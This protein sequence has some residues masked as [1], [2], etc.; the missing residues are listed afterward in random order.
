[1]LIQFWPITKIRTKRLPHDVPYLLLLILVLFNLFFITYSLQKHAAFQTAGFDL[2]NYNQAM[3]NT[4]QG[5]PLSITTMQTVSSRW[6]LHFEPILLL[7]TPVY[8][9]F[10][11]PQTLLVL[12]VVIVSLG[13]IPVF[14]LAQKVLVSDLAALIFAV[15]YLLFPALQGALV[16]DF[17]ALALAPAFLAWALWFMV[18]QRYGLVLIMVLLAMGCKENVALMV[19]MLGGYITFIQRQYRWGAIISGIAIVWF[20]AVNF[21]IIPWASPTGD[22]IHL[23]RYSH[24]GNNMHEIIQ[25]LAF[26]PVAMLQFIF[27]GD[28]L[29]YWFRVTMPVAFIAL[30]EPF[31]LLIILPELTINT[32]SNYPPNHQLDRFHYSVTIVPFVVVAGIYG[33]ARLLKFA[34]PK[35]KHVKPGFLKHVLLAM[36]LLVT[37]MYQVQFGHTP[38]G[39]NFGWPT[40][41]EHDLKA[42]KMM[43]QVPPD[44]AVAAQNN[45]ATRVSQREWIFILPKLS[46]QGRQ[47]DYIAMDMHSS[48]VPYRYIDEYCT[49]IED[50]L[51]DP[52]YGLIFSDDGL[53][54]F[55]Q[56]V[57]DS[58]IFEPM[59]PCL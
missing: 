23:T 28:R 42:E 44:S 47:A 32:L 5:T 18:T 17:H 4:L 30:V 38:I 20:I 3:W 55:K 46:Q 14:L 53:L 15:I 59:S 51:N 41:T 54:L 48:L 50:F 9:L 39:R 26:H 34:E 45:L 33:L 27:E 1:M 35:F 37:L 13:A 25:N 43:T 36:I 21:L 16:F 49:Q 57:P 31:V 24:W 58:A 12:Q 19:F 2:G 7:L 8:A 10:P 11:S 40:V 52:N 29:N 6:Q 56:G 22:N